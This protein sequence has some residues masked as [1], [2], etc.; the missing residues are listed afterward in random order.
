MPFATGHS[1]S[2]EESTPTSVCL[3]VRATGAHRA[4][5]PYHA[6]ATRE[7]FENHPIHDREVEPTID[8]YTGHGIGH[9]WGAFGL[10][11]RWE[12]SCVEKR[13]DES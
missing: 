11:C 2:E 6:Q 8:G 10:L 7:H 13:E 5:E 12:P 1:Q 4:P 3:L 9:P